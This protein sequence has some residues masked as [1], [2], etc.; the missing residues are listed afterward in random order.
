LAEK[1]L[2]FKLLAAHSVGIPASE[3]Q[4]LARSVLLGRAATF[5]P[6]QDVFQDNQWWAA[7]LGMVEVEMRC[8]LV[9]ST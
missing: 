6:K 8:K 9:S 4:G 5:G 3:A 2:H 1:I 7:P